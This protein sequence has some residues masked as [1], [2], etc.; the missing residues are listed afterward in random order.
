MQ[1]ALFFAHF[2]R[3]RRL[4]SEFPFWFEIVA[5]IHGF[6]HRDKTR[7]TVIH[8]NAAR[9][10]IMFNDSMICGILR[11]FYKAQ[12]ITMIKHK[13]Q[14]KTCALIYP[15]KLSLLLALC[16]YTTFY[17]PNTVTFGTRPFA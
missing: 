15:T 3:G 5:K 1:N 14:W 7:R 4:V 9:T 16:A 8:K 6:S 13:L 2:S 10:F 17:L 12:L 11:D